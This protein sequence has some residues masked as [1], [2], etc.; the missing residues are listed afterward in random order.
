MDEFIFSYF[1]KQRQVKERILQ[2]DED[3]KGHHEAREKLVIKLKEQRQRERLNS[4]GIDEDAII[5]VRIIEARDLT[6]MD[7][8]GKADPYCVLRFGN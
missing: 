4:Y 1:E 2:L 5:S 3:I 6:P 8:T 7:I